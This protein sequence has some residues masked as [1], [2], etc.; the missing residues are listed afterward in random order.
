M[1]PHHII[2]TVLDECPGPWAK[3]ALGGT[4]D[5]CQTQLMLTLKQEIGD[6]MFEEKEEVLT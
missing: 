6:F 4:C 2:I 5:R 1:E 3:E